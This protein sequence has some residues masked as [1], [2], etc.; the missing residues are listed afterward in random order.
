MDY[1][2]NYVERIRKD[3]HK[4]I[5]GIRNIMSELYP[6]ADSQIHDGMNNPDN[7]LSSAIESVK[8]SG[9]VEN[10]VDRFHKGDD[11]AAASLYFI[12]VGSGLIILFTIVYDLW[13]DKKLSL[14]SLG[15][16]RL[17][18]SRM[19][20]RIVASSINSGFD[21][22][23]DWRESID[24]IYE[25]QECKP[26]IEKYLVV[27]NKKQD[28]DT[29]VSTEE[30]A[31]TTLRDQDVEDVCENLQDEQPVNQPNEEPEEASVD[32][33]EQR[34]SRTFA[35]FIFCDQDKKEQIVN[36]VIS[37]LSRNNSGK[38]LA[39]MKLALEEINLVE[40]GKLKPFHLALEK[41]VK[42]VSYRQ[43]NRVYQGYAYLSNRGLEQ[44]TD[45]EEKELKRI[46]LDYCKGI[47]DILKST[48]FI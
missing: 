40:K 3:G 23:E 48:D 46:E 29:N 16:S 39:C 18:L 13:H 1:Y 47:T 45:Y 26:D 22:V 35:D 25:G 32:I 34:N 17:L 24:A 6:G 43:V 41:V 4:G 37:E 21:T 38:Y 8:K 5:A 7:N 11:Q 30:D 19:C 28:A 9:F 12:V 20:K 42:V 10:M 44:C 15:L 36:Y 2:A 27:F 14:K 31:E 33:K